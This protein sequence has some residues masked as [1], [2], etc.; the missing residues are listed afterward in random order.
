VARASATTATLQVSAVF[1]RNDGNAASAATTQARQR[2]RS[3]ACGRNDGN[4]A[5]QRRV[6]VQVASDF[7]PVSTSC[8]YRASCAETLGVDGFLARR[9]MRA[10][11]EPAAPWH[12][13]DF[14]AMSE[15]FA[16]KVH[17]I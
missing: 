2:R 1:G 17:H 8:G 15:R 14:F 12:E 9:A 10:R 16:G 7:D 13:P 3:A 4:A 5:G 11:S 6:R